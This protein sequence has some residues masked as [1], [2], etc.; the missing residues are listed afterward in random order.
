MQVLTSNKKI[1]K[2]FFSSLAGIKEE[3][4]IA[5]LTWKCALPKEY[6]S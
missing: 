6:A 1:L 2:F 5:N 4:P 3:I